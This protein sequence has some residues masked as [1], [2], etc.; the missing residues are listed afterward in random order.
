MP[1]TYTPAPTAT[2]AGL[3][4]AAQ[5]KFGDYVLDLS[6]EQDGSQV[7]VMRH[8]LRLDPD[9]RKRLTS[10]GERIQ[11]AQADAPEVVE[12]RK[13]LEQAI[14]RRDR[15]VES[16]GEDGPSARVA[17]THDARIETERDKVRQAEEAYNRS[18]A[19]QLAAVR[20]VVCE[21]VRDTVADPAYAQKLIDELG[22][23]ITMHIAL[24][25]EY[26]NRG[27]TGEA[28]PSES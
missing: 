10:V 4:Q 18:E 21:L 28:Q 22:D 11:D 25:E 1:T 13:K 24:V 12:A 6:P 9:V 19:E 15:A 3:R 16:A 17:D 27:Q 20:E 5:K 23:D 14:D 8:P 26:T 7:V 2:L